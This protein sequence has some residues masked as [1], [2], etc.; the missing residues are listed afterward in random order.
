MKIL[1]ITLSFF[2]N[3]NCFAQIQFPQD[4]FFGV[5]NAPGQIEDKLDDIWME[6]ADKNKIVAF[7][8][9][10]VP[11][12]KLGFWTRPEIEIDLAVST[13]ITTYRMGIDWGR[14]MPTPDTFD[15]SAIDH[16]KK[17]I[18]LIRSKNLKIMMTLMHHS[19]PKW[20]LKNGWLEK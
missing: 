19:I 9:E 17:I 4:F 15:Q 5:A 16:Y 13:G 10:G 20:A 18:K 14:V 1:S 7:K 2:I 6:W 3:F 12:D 8:N 11:K